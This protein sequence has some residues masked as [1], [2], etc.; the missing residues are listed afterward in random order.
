MLLSLS[1][2]ATSAPVIIEPTYVD[3][4]KNCVA[5]FIFPRPQFEAARRATWHASAEGVP[6]LKS[7]ISL[8]PSAWFGR[9]RAPG[10]DSVES[11]AKI[12]AAKVDRRAH[13][14][15]PSCFSSNLRGGTKAF[16]LLWV[17][18][19]RSEDPGRKSRAN[20]QRPARLRS[21]PLIA[22]VTALR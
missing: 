21:L 3:R 5:L 19:V 18:Q 9:R 10:I 15:P 4:T 17:L 8:P 14:N 12:H 7:L 22:H 20:I 1:S 13:G 2:V 16:F 6:Q 11:R